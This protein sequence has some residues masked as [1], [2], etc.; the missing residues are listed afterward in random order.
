MP[1]SRL[2]TTYPLR[3]V[4]AAQRAPWGAPS[5]RPNVAFRNLKFRGVSYIS[6]FIFQ[7]FN[8]NGIG[9]GIENYNL[10]NI[11]ELDIY[12][13]LLNIKD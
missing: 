1:G 3:S 2:T 4:P 11:E 9:I 10:L 7:Y 6:Y 5:S 8:T 12:D 13:F